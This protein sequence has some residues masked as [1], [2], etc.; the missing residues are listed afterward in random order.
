M[1]RLALPIVILLAIAA[2][3]AGAWYFLDRNFRGSS[4]ARGG[5]VISEQRALPPFTRLAVGGL[6]DITLVQGAA[7][8]MISLTGALLG[9]AFAAASLRWRPMSSGYH[10]SLVDTRLAP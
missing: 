5:E 10:R 7:E 3:V 4:A 8:S 9:S 2:A 1:N 6:A